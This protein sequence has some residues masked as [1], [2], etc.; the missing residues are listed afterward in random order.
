MSSSPRL[1]ATNTLVADLPTL[2]L[3]YGMLVVLVAMTV[4]AAAIDENFLNQ[5][6]LLNLLLQ[7]TPQGLMAIGMTYV[8]ISGGFDL[9]IGGTYAAGGVIFAALALNN[10]T[11]LALFI[12]LLAGAGI[13]LLIGTVITRLHVNPFVAT[14]GAGFIIRGI[15]QVGSNATPVIVDKADFTELGQGRLGVVPVPGIILVVSLI[16]GAAALERRRTLV[17]IIENEKRLRAIVTDQPGLICRFEP[18]GWLSFVNAAFCH[19]HA[20]SEAELL[21]TDFFLMLDADEAKKL[22]ANLESLPAENP[23]LDFDRRAAAAAGHVEWHQCHLRR[24][25]HD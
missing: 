15:A 7:W 20:Q 11:W 10:N 3:R 23:V 8:I 6:N 4:V 13:G 12:T 9:S 18:D 14:L 24:L 25:R 21:G 22:R 5:A 16:L 17:A 19:F 1:G 2:F